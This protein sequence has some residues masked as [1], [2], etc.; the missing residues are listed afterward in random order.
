MP[1]NSGVG[2]D[3]VV[4]HD[5]TDDDEIRRPVGS[6]TEFVDQVLFPDGR[7]QTPLAINAVDPQRF[8]IGTEVIY[9]EDPDLIPSRGEDVSLRNGETVWHLIDPAEPFL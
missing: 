5:V 2:A 6:G 4:V 9:E 1:P 3:L 8:L 7:F